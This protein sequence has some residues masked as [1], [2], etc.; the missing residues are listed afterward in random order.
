MKNTPNL[1]VERHRVRHGPYAS[2]RFDG[3]NGQ[4]FVPLA[5]FAGDRI[6]ALCMVSDGE[7]WEHVSVSVWKSGKSLGRCP[8]WEEMCH[9][10]DLSWNAEECV[11][12]YHP[13]RS[14]YRNLHPHVLHLWRSVHHAFPEPSA[15]FVAPRPGESEEEAIARFGRSA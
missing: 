7:G 12:Q 5:S 6:W 8:T 3:N 11:V 4:F 15:G 14:E 1:A 13:R 10:K 9:V 2:S